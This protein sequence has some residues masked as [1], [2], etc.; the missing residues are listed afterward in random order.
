MNVMFQM[1]VQDSDDLGAS[2]QSEDEVCNDGVDNDL[3]GTADEG[4]CDTDSD[5]T[6]DYLCGCDSD[7]GGSLEMGEYGEY[8]AG[9]CSE[10]LYICTNDDGNSYVSGIGVTT[11]Q[12]VEEVSEVEVVYTLDRNLGT[13]TSDGGDVY[14]EDAGSSG[15]YTFDTLSLTLGT[16]ELTLTDDGGDTYISEDG[17]T[18]SGTQS[19]VS[20]SLVSVV[21]G[22]ICSGGEGTYYEADSDCEVLAAEEKTVCY[23]AGGTVISP[24]PCLTTEY[25][26]S[27]TQVCETTAVTQAPE[28]EMSSWQKF[29]SFLGF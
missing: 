11:E 17:V 15:T 28:G 26:D 22:A 12:V 24:T 13:I 9:D 23:T 10:E 3:D 1:Q 4:G 7:L 25:C 6:I 5:G 21:E 18:F 20:S 8:N 2:S 27:Q 14:T 16:D 29:L 19:I